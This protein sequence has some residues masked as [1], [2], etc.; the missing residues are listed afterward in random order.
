MSNE[1]GPHAKAQWRKERM[2]MYRKDAKALG[3]DEKLNVAAQVEKRFA[4]A[5]NCSGPLAAFAVK[6]FTAETLRR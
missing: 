5:R 2:K 1:K 6:C 4:A 3:A